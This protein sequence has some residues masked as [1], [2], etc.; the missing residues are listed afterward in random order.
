MFLYIFSLSISLYVC[1][2]LF[3]PGVLHKRLEKSSI[4][5][6]IYDGGT[7]FFFML[8]KEAFND[9]VTFNKLVNGGQQDGS[10]GQGTCY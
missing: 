10:A 5:L 8:F 2:G 1:M 9:V 4:S 6:W 7:H 3:E